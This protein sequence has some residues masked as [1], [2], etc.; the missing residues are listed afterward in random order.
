MQH[1]MCVFRQAN[2]LDSFQLHCLPGLHEKL[3][4]INW[5]VITVD[6]HFMRREQT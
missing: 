5:E 3:T 6:K 1:P 2:A 4:E